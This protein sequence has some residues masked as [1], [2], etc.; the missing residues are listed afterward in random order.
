MWRGVKGVFQGGAASVRPPP[1]LSEGQLSAEGET[2]VVY[3]V[4]VVV[5]VPLLP[6]LVAS[7]SASSSSCALFFFF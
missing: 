1:S 5:L 6:L 7:C 3:V 4:V 2:P